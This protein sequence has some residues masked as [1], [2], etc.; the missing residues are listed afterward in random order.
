VNSEPVNAYRN[1]NKPIRK[2]EEERGMRI[3][4]VDDEFVSRK[5]AQLNSPLR[6]LTPW[7]QR[8]RR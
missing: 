3:L 1:N 4:I 5:K 8:Q 2:L 7:P 6:N